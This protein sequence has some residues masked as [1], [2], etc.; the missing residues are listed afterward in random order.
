[1]IKMVEIRVCGP[2]RVRRHKPGTVPGDGHKPRAFS[3][4][5]GLE[6]PPQPDVSDTPGG[7][8]LG[9]HT[10]TLARTWGNA[11]GPLLVHTDKGKKST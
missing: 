7:T 3:G 5:E 8:G 4:C 2:E 1:M 10:A 11:Y 6:N 9:T